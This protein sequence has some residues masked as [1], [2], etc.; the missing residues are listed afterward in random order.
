[1][2]AND[3]DL[4]RE[5]RPAGSGSGSGRPR[6][7]ELEHTVDELAVTSGFSGVVQG[8][9]HGETR[10]CRAYGMADRANQRVNTVD[11]RFGLASGAKGFT[12]LAVL[13]LINEGRLTMDTTARS[14]LGADLPLIDDA[15]TVEQLLAHRSGIG[16]YCD[17]DAEVTDY[18]LSVPSWQL[19][20]TER[21]LPILDGFPQVFAPG[22]RFLYCNG[23]YAVLALLAER[24]SGEQLP[25]L[26]QRLVC[27]PAQLTDTAFLRSDELPERTAIGYLSSDSLR[28]NVF[29]LPVRGN[30]DG[31]IYSTV[32]DLHELWRALLAGE[33]LPMAVVT[34]VIRVHGEDPDSGRRYGL[35][36]WRDGAGNAVSLE[37]MDA[38]VSFRSAHDLDSGLS[39][40]VISNWTDGAWPIN[41]FLGQTLGC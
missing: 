5:D 13:G 41:R 14:L 24:A 23:G 29:H 25:E 35:G 32:A 11:T 17:D 22:E 15:V 3:A 27:E 16:D 20:S 36:F 31:G 26:V 21:Y 38:G 37:G 28:T 8:D 18:Q 33:I 6:W 7:D 4:I 9:E 34:E 2:A 39:Y 30:G 10:L 1:V 40:S 12:A 19:D